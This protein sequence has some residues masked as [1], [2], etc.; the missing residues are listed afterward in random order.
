MKN[1]KTEAQFKREYNR[2]KY[3]FLRE[4][5]KLSGQVSKRSEVAMKK[6]EGYG[7]DSTNGEEWMKT[8][9]DLSELCSDLEQSVD[10]ESILDL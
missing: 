10:D 6:A 7:S 8:S 1:P 5:I 4:V 2:L 9:D 3:N